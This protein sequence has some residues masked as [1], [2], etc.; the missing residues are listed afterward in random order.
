ME[1]AG[2]GRAARSLRR[3]RRKE[4]E[5]GGAEERV[6]GAAGASGGKVHA[7]M[8]LVAELQE[9]WFL[10]SRFLAMEEDQ[11]VDYVKVRL[12]QKTLI[13]APLVQ[14]R[15]SLHRRHGRGDVHALFQLRADGSLSEP[16]SR[17]K[18]CSECGAE[19]APAG[20]RLPTAGGDWAWAARTGSGPMW[21]CGDIFAAARLWRGRLLT[22]GR[23]SC[24]HPVVV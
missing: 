14:F 12:H 23:L 4:A 20:H 15:V 6:R 7:T 19:S 24:R 22:T 3:T 16:M 13:V 21:M 11:L 17:A 2:D 9:L 5:E 10:H 8:G 18:F 1:E